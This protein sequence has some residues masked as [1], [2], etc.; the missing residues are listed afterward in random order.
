MSI[1]QKGFSLIEVLLSLFL[2][3]TVAL[4]L[5]QQQTVNTAIYSRIQ[6][7]QKALASSDSIQETSSDSIYRASK[8]KEI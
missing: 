6:L 1:T 3:S 4:F 2:V 5:L 8:A 7:F